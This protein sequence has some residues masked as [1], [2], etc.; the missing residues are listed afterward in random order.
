MHLQAEASALE[1]EAATWELLLHMYADTRKMYP[2]GTGG[3]QTA[4]KT[5][6]LQ[7]IMYAKLLKVIPQSFYAGKPPLQKRVT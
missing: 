6:R 1:A 2:A 3:Q 4:V 7:C 5:V